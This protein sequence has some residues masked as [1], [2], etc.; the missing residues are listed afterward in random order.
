MC[1]GGGIFF[2]NKDVCFILS[3]CFIQ[4]KKNCQCFSIQAG[5]KQPDSPLVCS[6]GE[7]LPGSWEMRVSARLCLKDWKRPPTQQ[8]DLS[9]RPLLGGFLWIR[10]I[11]AVSSQIK[12]WQELGFW[13]WTVMWV[14]ECETT[15]FTSLKN[16]V[17]LTVWKS[18]TRD[19]RSPTK[20]TTLLAGGCFPS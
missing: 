5:N 3:E 20:H 2:P 19:G 4:L 9:S 15:Q 18:S 13:S 14:P 6:C 12:G 17:F 10:P 7:A 8:T 16:P 1:R 11:N